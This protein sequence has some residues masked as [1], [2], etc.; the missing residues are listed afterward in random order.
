M[1]ITSVDTLRTVAIFVVVCIHVV[2]ITP[3]G[4]LPM[5]FW[6]NQLNRCAVPFFFV[7][8]SYFF[9]KTLLAGANATD[10]YIRYLTRLTTVFIVWSIIYAFMYLPNKIRTYGILNGL[11]QL[12]NGKIAWAIDNPMTFLL[13]GFAIHLWFITSLILALTILYGLILLNKPNKIFYIA[14]PL[15]VFGLLAGTYSMTPMGIAFEFNTRNGPFLST[16]CIGMGWWLAQRDFKPT[17]QLALAIILVSFLLQVTEYLLLSNSYSLPTDFSQ[18]TPNQ[19]KYLIGTAFFG[20]GFMLLALAIPQLGKN[21]PLPEWGKF[22]LGIYVAHL[23]VLNYAG[24]L[25]TNLPNIMQQLVTAVVVYFTTLAIVAILA[26]I[27]YIR[28]IVV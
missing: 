2:N 20:A 11:T 15:Y 4:N 3:F 26:R 5:D 13:Q 19:G 27:K 6:F 9:T 10:L 24:K 8:S 28:P 17:I 14:I 18:A 16:L 7:A 22:T 1:R 21:T 12:I 25:T 23:F